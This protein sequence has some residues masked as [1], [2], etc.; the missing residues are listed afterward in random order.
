EGDHSGLG[1]TVGGMDGRSVEA[2][3][4]R[5]HGD[6]TGNAGVDHEAGGGAPDVDVVAQIHREVVFP[7]LIVHVQEV[8]PRGDAHDVHQHLEAAAEENNPHAARA[9]T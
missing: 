2:V 9:D 6:T 3:D 7:G 8:G 1:H 4:R 5:H